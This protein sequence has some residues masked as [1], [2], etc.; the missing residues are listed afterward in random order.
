MKNINP[1]G[2][3]VCKTEGSTISKNNEKGLNKIENQ[4]E[5]WYKMLQN[6][7]KTDFGEKIYQL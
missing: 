3:K 2:N 7:Q 4:G 5:I 6:G 1:T